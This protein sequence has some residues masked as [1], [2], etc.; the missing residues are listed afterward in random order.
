VY[1]LSSN[2][3][4]LNGARRVVPRSSV[5]DATVDHSRYFGIRA[6]RF[7]PF[8]RAH[9][10]S[11]SRPV[12]LCGQIHVPTLPRSFSPP[13]VH[14]I[15]WIKSDAPLAGSDLQ[16]WA[17]GQSHSKIP[18]SAPVTAASLFLKAHHFLCD[19]N[20]SAA[21]S[22]VQKAL[23]L[24]ASQPAS[25]CDSWLILAANALFKRDLDSCELWLRHAERSLHHKSTV[26]DSPEF[27]RQAG[28]LF[29]LQACLFA[30]TNHRQKSA[31]LLL[32]AFLCHMNAKAFGSA[33]LDLVLR[34]RL[35]ALEFKWTDAMEIL[36][37]AEN[38][39]DSLPKPPNAETVR[40][41]KTIVNDRNALLRRQNVECVALSN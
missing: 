38:T 8:A 19:G 33:A 20:Q 29:V 17:V 32:E 26:V 3:L 5:A 2:L 11:E 6:V 14:P 25:S 36:D 23:G 7:D 34:S 4:L 40:L 21:E 22:C 10:R 41:Q 37:L 13:A 16:A 9:F 28:D 24:Q 35:M 15:A 27:H 1:R 39:L 12:L 30:Q 31:N 18:V